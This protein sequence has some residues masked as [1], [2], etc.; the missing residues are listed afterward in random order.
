MQ[1]KSPTYPWAAFIA[2]LGGLVMSR[3]SRSGRNVA[4]DAKVDLREH[5]AVQ[6]Q[7]AL[8]TEHATDAV[9]RLD[10]DGGC[11]FASPS[12]RDILGYAPEALVGR[13]MLTRF[14]PDDRRHGFNEYQ[15]LACGDAERCVITARTRRADVTSDWMWLEVSLGVIRNT[16]DRQSLEIIASARDVTQ[17]KELEIQLE[18]ARERAEG[19]VKVKSSFLANMSHEIRTPMNGVIGFTELLLTGELNPE[20]RHQVQLIADS[21][22]AMMRLLND[23]LDLSRMEAGQMKICNEPFDLAHALRNCLQL[24]TP[25]VNQKGLKLECE[26]SADLPTLVN[27]DGLRVRQI[28]LNLLGNAAKFTLEGSI[29]LRARSLDEASAQVVIEVEDTGIGIEKDRQPAI[30]M[31]FVQADSRT[32]SRFG[33]SGLG[34]TISHQLAQLMG[35][36]LELESEPGR[37]SCFSLVLPLGEVA[38]RRAEPRANHAGAYDAFASPRQL[39]RT[40]VAEDHDVN[41]LLISAMLNELGCVVDVAKNGVEALTMVNEAVGRNEPY[42]VVLMDMRM[43][44]MGGLEATRRIRAAGI[45]AHDLPIVALTANAYADD[46]AACIASGM[47]GHLAKPIKLAELR[48]A[49]MRWTNLRLLPESPVQRYRLN[50]ALCD[51]YRARK[52]ETAQRLEELMRLGHVADPALTEVVDMLHKLAGT[53]QIFGEGKLGDEVRLLELGIGSASGSERTGHVSRALQAIRATG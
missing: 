44:E 48:L 49:L 12:V 53:A 8:L 28:V 15:G 9:L 18:S 32:A 46:V 4:H 35:G 25:A 16:A 50:A 13:N 41:Q 45:G 1:V 39:T 17:R 33:G 6:A 20:Q 43:P 26:L 37:G 51:R 42:A 36:R 23:I 38:D 19:A 31:P 7:L 5:R 30:F 34:L 47:Q 40:L 52:A 27:G 3:L 14:H 21:G 22:R 24:L 10:L 29:T 2:N 11:L